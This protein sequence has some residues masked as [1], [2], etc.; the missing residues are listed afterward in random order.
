MRTSWEQGVWQE[1]EV[2]VVL[3]G[4]MGLRLTVGTVVALVVK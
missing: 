1:M 2:V 3:K 4:G